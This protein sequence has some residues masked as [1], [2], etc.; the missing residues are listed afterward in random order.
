MDRQSGRMAIWLL[1]PETYYGSIYFG[2][3]DGRWRYD[4]VS[5]R[6]LRVDGD[7]AFDTDRLALEHLKCRLKVVRGLNRIRY[8]RW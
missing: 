6:K 5:K 1:C 3:C 4:T 8:G 2:A 7:P